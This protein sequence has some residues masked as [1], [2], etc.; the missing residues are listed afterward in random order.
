[1]SD[2][3]TDEGI[4]TLQGGQDLMI[5]VDGKMVPNYDAT[6]MSFEE[7]DIVTGTVV[8]VDKD[9]VLVDIGYKSEGVVPAN[10]LAR[11]LADMADAMAARAPLS[12]RYA[13]EAVLQGLDLTLE[14]GL[15]LEAD[16]YHLL[17]TTEDRVEGI[18]SFL[19][20]RPPHFKGR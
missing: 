18:R 20:R 17:Q 8:R 9:E 5:E 16:L 11:T 13:K 3:H 19:E 15:H 2:E 7:G 14:Q 10:E 6:M 1:M 12:L 4:Q